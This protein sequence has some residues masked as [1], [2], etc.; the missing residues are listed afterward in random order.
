LLDVITKLEGTVLFC[1]D[2]QDV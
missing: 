2:L 1:C